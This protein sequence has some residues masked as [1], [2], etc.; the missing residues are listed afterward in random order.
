MENFIE[1]VENDIFK[2][3]NY[4]RIK[5]NSNQKRKPLKDIQK[6]T[7]KTC[8]IQDKGSCFVVLD[9]ESYIKKIDRD[10][11]EVLFNN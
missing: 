8:R 3:T 10:L 6:D 4:K 11:Q 1:L 9:S 2:P 7:L 5:N